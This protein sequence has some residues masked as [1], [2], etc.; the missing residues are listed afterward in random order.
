MNEKNENKR[1]IIL[2]I[3]IS[4]LSLIGVSFLTFVLHKIIKG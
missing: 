2:F 4:I 3:I 1:W